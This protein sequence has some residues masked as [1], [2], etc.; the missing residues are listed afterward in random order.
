MSA[1]RIVLLQHS[2][3]VPPGYLGDTLDAAGVS[4]VVTP[5]HRGGSLPRLGDVDG[6]VTLGGTMGA[7]EEAAYP[8]LAAEKDFLRRAVGSGVPVL[9]VCLGCQLLA[10]ALGG[11]AYR[12]GTAEVGFMDVEIVTSDPVMREMDGPVVVFHQ[13]TWDLPPGGQLIARS[14]HHPQAFRSGSALGIQP[15]P[16]ATP[17]MVASWL[18]TPAGGAEAAEAG[19]DAEAMLTLMRDARSVSADMAVR[20]FGA[21]IREVVAT[22]S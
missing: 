19:T 2:D 13:D 14:D 22:A 10:D 18:A 6:V 20:L 21:W 17:E 16:E 12:A 9:G 8:F 1:A 7:Y 5:L 11:G 4:S 15:H 3:E